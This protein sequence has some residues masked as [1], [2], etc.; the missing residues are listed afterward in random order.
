MRRVDTDL[1]VAEQP[2]RF[3]LV[4]LGARMTVIRLA[5]SSLL[6]YSP[7][8]FS[9]DLRA[10]LEGLG[11]IRYLVAPNRFH[12]LFMSDY[13]DAHPDARLYVAPGLPE[14]RADLSIEGVLPKDARHR[15]AA[16]TAHRSRGRPSWDPPAV[17]AT[18]EPVRPVACP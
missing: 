5:G 1:W 15:P 6:I 2:L 16:R 3:G 17:L 8:S 4:E 14:K 18:R 13:V 9:E 10:E 7:I 12:H 11:E